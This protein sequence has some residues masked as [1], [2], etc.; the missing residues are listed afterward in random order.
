MTKRKYEHQESDIDRR[1]E[2]Y[3]K[4]RAARAMVVGEWLRQRKQA[5]YAAIA[6]QFK[7]WAS[8]LDA[9]LQTLKVAGVVDW[10]DWK[11]AP[12][13]IKY[14]A[15]RRIE[16]KIMPYNSEPII[17]KDNRTYPTAAVSDNYFRG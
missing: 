2:A 4:T 3:E 12:T 6:R 5:T 9:I 1:E 7:E 15:M 13:L 11:P 17:H 16:P 14:Q 10:C 8:E